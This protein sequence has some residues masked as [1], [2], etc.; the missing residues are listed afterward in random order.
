M[1]SHRQRECNLFAPK[2]TDHMDN[3]FEETKAIIIQEIQRGVEI[4]DK[5]RPT[6]LA[7]DFSKDG[8][9]FWLL[10]KHCECTSSKPFCCPLGWKVTLV[11]SRF[12][13]PAESRYSPIE[14]EALAEVD[15]L[16]KT[17]HFALGCPN[18][19]IA[20]DHRLLPLKVFGERSLEAIPNPRLRNLK[21]KTLKY[22][23]HITHTPGVRH[24]AADTISRN[25]VGAANR[26]AYL[27]M[28]TWF[29][30]TNP[31]PYLIASLRLSEHSQI[32]LRCAPVKKTPWVGLALLPG[33]MFVWP[34]TITNLIPY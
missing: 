6:C 4:F 17:R 28:Q 5:R 14:G 21:E 24:V 29:P 19:I 12:T 25:T 30:P 23:F 3:L 22:R 16:E 32:Y 13:S 26:L 11:G 1:P 10:Q 15:A 8:I 31:R 9:R 2:W 18:L 7:T 34:L 33:P 27:M 20:V